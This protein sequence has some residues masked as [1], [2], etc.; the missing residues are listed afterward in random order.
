LASATGG[1]LVAEAPKGIGVEVAF[2]LHGV[3]AV[4]DPAADRASA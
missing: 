4:P 2:G 3:A 1:D